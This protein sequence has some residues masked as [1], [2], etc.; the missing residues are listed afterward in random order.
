MSDS[1]ESA[2][3][4]GP[5]DW[6]GLGPQIK[7]SKSQVLSSILSDSYHGVSDVCEKVRMVTDWRFW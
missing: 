1:L 2:Q 6:H 3:K 5:L 4:F 7:Q